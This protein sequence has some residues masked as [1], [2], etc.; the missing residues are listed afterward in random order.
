MI[1]DARDNNLDPMTHRS[2]MVYASGVLA[3]AYA[4]NVTARSVFATFGPKMVRD[5]FMDVSL[6]ASECTA[7]FFKR[8]RMCGERRSN[9]VWRGEC[10]ARSTGPPRRRALV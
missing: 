8:H 2:R 9:I 6:R 3:D 7:V 4:R 1:E 5:D 10:D